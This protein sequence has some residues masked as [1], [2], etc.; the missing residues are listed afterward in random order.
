[1]GEIKGIQSY[2]FFSFFTFIFHWKAAKL[3]T[4][5]GSAPQ[6]V[7]FNSMICSIQASYSH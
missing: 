7:I 4:S 5:F 6:V 2:I 3:V 1:V